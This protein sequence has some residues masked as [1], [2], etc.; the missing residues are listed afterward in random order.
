MMSKDNGNPAIGK[1]HQLMNTL[2]YLGDREFKY[3]VRNLFIKRMGE[4]LPKA[5]KYP[6]L[7]FQALLPQKLGG[8]DLAFG[9]EL[10]YCLAQSPY[11]TQAVVNKLMTGVDCSEEIRILRTMNKNP[12][13]RG[14]PQ[15]QAFQEQIEHEFRTQQGLGSFMYQG[16]YKSYHEVIQILAEKGD[17]R[18]DLEKLRRLGWMTTQD[19]AE[20]ACRGNIFQR[21]IIQ[22][23]EK[24]QLFN[25]LKWSSRYSRIR[26]TLIESAASYGTP[27]YPIDQR[28]LKLSL[29]A[30]DAPLF[31]NIQQEAIL[32]IRSPWDPDET[33]PV[34]DTL[35]NVL[36]WGRPSLRL[37][38]A[39]VGL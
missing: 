5:R 37:G 21:L 6:R 13:L 23:V 36:D 2:K 39:F 3:M 14:I 24:R 35:Q 30:V 25:T 15:L 22:G 4:Y 38:K 20:L 1:A 19:A 12:S 16:E 29:E 33:V 17:S 34:Y 11:P 27:E 31:V 7:F 10:D 18:L 9:D 28:K 32:F 26:E 8:L